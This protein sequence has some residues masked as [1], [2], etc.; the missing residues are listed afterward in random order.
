[1]NLVTF[2]G[3]YEFSAKDECCLLRYMG[4]IAAAQCAPFIAAANAE[5]F[6]ATSKPSLKAK[7]VAAVRLSA[8]AAN[9]FRE[10]MMHALRNALPRTRQSSTLYGDKD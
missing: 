6:G 3:D 9:S 10:V 7:P 5:M 2:I 1:M 8:Y 4:E